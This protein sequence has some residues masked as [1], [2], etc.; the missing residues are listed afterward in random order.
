MRQIKEKPCSA[1]TEKDYF[2]ILFGELPKEK[3]LQPPAKQ[4]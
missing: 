1:N 4:Q 2:M 3:A